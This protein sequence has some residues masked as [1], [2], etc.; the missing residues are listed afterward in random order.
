MLVLGFRVVFGL[1]GV[2]VLEVSS[3]GYSQ[4]QADL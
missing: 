3:R 1:G 4:A 2:L